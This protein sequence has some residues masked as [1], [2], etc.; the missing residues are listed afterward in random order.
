MRFAFAFQHSSFCGSLEAASA[1]IEEMTARFEAIHTIVYRRLG[2]FAGWPANYGV[3]AWGDEIVCVFATGRLGRESENLHLEDQ[4]H[5]FTPVQARSLDGGLTWQAEPFCGSVPGARNLSADEHVTK[6]LEAGPNVD[7]AFDLITLPTPIDFAD[8]EQVVMAART[9][10]SGRSVSW[11][12]VSKDRARSWNGPF[13]F[14]GLKSHEEALSARTDIITLGRHD[15]LF[16]LTAPKADGTEGRILCARTQDGGLSF[17]SEGFVWD[18]QT[19]YAIMPSSTRLADG[20][21]YTVVRRRAHDR[22]WLEAYRSADLGRTWSCVGTP[23]RNTGI[24]GN[25]PALVALPDER[26]VLLYGFRDPPF[27][28]SAVVSRD[29]GGTWSE[30]AVLR[31]DGDDADLGYPC[32]LV[33]QDGKIIVVYYF[34]DRDGPERFIAASILEVPTLS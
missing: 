4:H 19:G 2:A 29:R 15:A 1:G 20:T 31:D 5:A 16:M 23:V 3:W 22:F 7:P 8:G 26:L 32:A 21:I 18:E 34:N 12:Y 25:P 9:G 28:L 11:F 10:I 17:S 6:D 33:R 24:M 14:E 13:R 30:P 27:G